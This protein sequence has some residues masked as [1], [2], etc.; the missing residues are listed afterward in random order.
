MLAI[1]VCGTALFVSE[2]GPAEAATFSPTYTVTASPTVANAVAD[3]NLTIATPGGDTRW[4]Q[5]FFFTDPGATI[6]PGPDHA[7]YNPGTHP[8]PGVTVGSVNMNVRLGLTNSACDVELTPAW[9]LTNESVDAAA[10]PPYLV[11]VFTPDGGSLVQPLARYEGTT[12]VA[13]VS[14]TWD[15]VAFEPGDLSAFAAPHPYATD[16]GNPALGYPMAIFLRNPR[17]LLQ[18]SPTAPTAVTDMCTGP[19]TSET[20]SITLLGMASDGNVRYRNPG[21]G[22]GIFKMWFQSHRDADNDG[23]EN[24]L[25]TCPFQANL[26][27]PRVTTGPDGD[28]L[29]SVCDPTPGTDTNAGN[30]DADAS[31]GS[32]WLNAGDNCPTVVNGTQADS[33]WGGVYATVA[34]DGGPRGDHIGDA[35]DPDDTRADTEGHY[36][37]V[38]PPVPICF[39]GTDADADGWCA[40]HGSNA[41]LND[42]NDGDPNVT[43]ERYELFF[44]MPMG[45]SGG[46]GG[47]NKNP[48]SNSNAGE[49]YQVCND[50]SDNDGDTLTDL[51]DPGCMPVGLS[52]TDS[53][54]DGFSDEAEIHIGTRANARCGVGSEPG[55][56]ESWP[57]DLVSGGLPESTDRINIAD[58]SSFV[59]PAPRKLG[60]APG[61]AGFSPR[62]DLNPGVPLGGQWI[63]VIDL[64]T[65]ISGLPG[66]PPMFGGMRA[67][68][69]PACTPHPI[70]GD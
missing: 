41:N 61:N 14:F 17:D 24:P 65:L 59:A 53:D 47:L 26:E 25:D 30:H 52:A 67:F 27:D 18:S 4:H 55:P 42:P 20:A 63:N 45:H 13:G 62:W 10:M 48:A 39:G 31:G 37:V 9:T 54:G 50:G 12:T 2:G 38:D 36:H 43:P 32:P 8:G 19:A 3:L 29:D 16:L 51:L 28:M 57:T 7:T 6:S 11:D 21:T 15:M 60:T 58:L 40:I 49:P 44:P 23:I 34:V 22:T 64:S 70:F 35:C 46:G 1:V 68:S 56:S 33:E 5:V 69:G 66:N